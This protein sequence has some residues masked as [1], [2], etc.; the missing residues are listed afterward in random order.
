MVKFKVRDIEQLIIMFKEVVV[1]I[2]LITF[3][4]IIKV[5]IN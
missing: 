2:V 3:K 4:A 1:K 5:V